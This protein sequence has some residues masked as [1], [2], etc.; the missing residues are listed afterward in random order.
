VERLP[1]GGSPYGRK[2]MLCANDWQVC[3]ER[4]TDDT[5]TH[6]HTHTHNNVILTH[7]HTHTLTH[8][9]T[10]MHAYGMAGSTGASVFEAGIH[11]Q[12]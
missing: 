6:T 7:T 1:L 2:V 11:S 9:H 12:K 5:H 3:R 10:H 8:T 4:D